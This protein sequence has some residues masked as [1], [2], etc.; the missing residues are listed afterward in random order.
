MGNADRNSAIDL[1]VDG[2]QP[3]TYPK[4]AHEYQFFQLVELMNRIDVER[5]S[6]SRGDWLFT[7][8]ASLG[9]APADVSSLTQLENGR[10]LLET[11]FLG[12]SGAQSPL[13]GF[14]L[15][16]LA[17]ESEEGIKRPFLDFFNH[18]A[19]HLF[20]EV[21]RKYR[22]YLRFQSNATD[23]MSDQFFALVGLGDANFRT[24]TPINWSKMLSYAGTLASRNRSPQVVAG[25]IAHCFDLDCVHIRQWEPRSVVI[26]DGQRCSLGMQNIS[27]GQNSVI[28][29]VATDVRGKF[30]ICIDGLTP[31]R[32]EDFLPSG[33]EF[34]PLCT[35]VE[36]VLREQLAYDL[37]LH[38]ADAES[39][40]VR[41]T[42]EHNVKLGWSSFLGTP[43]E[44]KRILIQVRQ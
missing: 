34:L 38:L 18:R 10:W 17:T 23:P 43:Q 4:D 12:L 27:L 36:F 24:D 42:P 2:E 1:E 28:G 11:N 31:S 30:T 41:L 21:W 40:Q 37:E 14:M 26:E 20:S 6:D 3:I 19:I 25:I 33:K 15:E 8:N 13:P 5:E 7:A 29:E 9:F 39:L 16:R 44:D 35:L 22:Y 32:F